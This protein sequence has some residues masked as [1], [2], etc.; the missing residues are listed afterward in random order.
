MAK[1]YVLNR[2][3]HSYTDA[4]RFG[5]LIYCTDGSLDKFDTAEMYRE[6]VEALYDS[7]PEDYIVLGSLTSL[8][9]V[10]C[11]IFAAKHLR[12][13]LLIH[14]P[15]GYTARSLYLNHLQSTGYVS[16]T[17]SQR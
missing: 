14:R 2:G 5:E 17:N 16:S 13:N 11:A 1:V 15:D 10:A 6:L 7:L 9:S 4:E 3:P 12:L 8:C